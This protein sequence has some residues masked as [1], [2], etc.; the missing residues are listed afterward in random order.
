[1]LIHLR[2]LK[3][4]TEDLAWASS[5][6][7][8][9]RQTCRVIGWKRVWGKT[10][11]VFPMPLGDPIKNKRSHDTPKATNETEEWPVS[12]LNYRLVFWQKNN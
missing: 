2:D 4:I 5:A 6:R 9:M 12:L 8:A 1:M 7:E 11:E 10:K 3:H